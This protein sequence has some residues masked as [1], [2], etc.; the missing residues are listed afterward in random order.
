MVQHVDEKSMNIIPVPN[1]MMFNVT[2]AEGAARRAALEAAR[3]AASKVTPG[4]RDRAIA[5]AAANVR[6]PGIDT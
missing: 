3:A 5:E 1:N 4:Q 6:S 2:E